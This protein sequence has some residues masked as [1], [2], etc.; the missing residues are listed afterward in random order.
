MIPMNLK[1]CLLASF[2]LFCLACSKTASVLELEEELKIPLVESIIKPDFLN[3]D[4]RKYKYDDSMPDSFSKVESIQSSFF[5]KEYNM[6][7]RTIWFVNIS[8]DFSKDSIYIITTLQYRPTI[9][10]GKAP[11]YGLEF[12]YK[13]ARNNLKLNADST[14]TYL[15]NKYLYSKLLTANWADPNW[16]SQAML[17]FPEFTDHEGVQIEYLSSS[18]GFIYE[19][20]FFTMK[21]VTWDEATKEIKMAGTFKVAIKG[22][23]CGFYNFYEVQNA[24]FTATIK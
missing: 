19:N 6:E 12:V 18:N 13:E 1:L 15:D 22:L 14:F 16:E 23:S 11:Y 9:Q 24:D 17:T 2:A 3:F 7:K 8:E 5:I 4:I 21:S 20:E 10:T